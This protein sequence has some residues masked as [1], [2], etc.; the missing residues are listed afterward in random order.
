MF[1]ELMILDA[2]AEQRDETR[3]VS[4]AHKKKPLISDNHRITLCKQTLVTISFPMFTFSRPTSF[5]RCSIKHFA[6]TVFA[7][8]AQSEEMLSD[9]RQWKLNA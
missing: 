5:L 6:S 7:L 4:A 9:S 3:K 8:A 2:L 1:A